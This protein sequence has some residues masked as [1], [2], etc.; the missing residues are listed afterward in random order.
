MRISTQ[1]AS[2]AALN[3]LM[4]AQRDA[5]DARGQIST[6]KAA[7]DLKGYGGA[8]ETIMTARAAKVRAESFV[9]ANERLA[10]RLQV[11]DLAYRELSGAAND[12]R[13][14]L[15]SSDG[16]GLMN[17]VRTAFDR[18]VGALSTKFGGS[19]VFG[20]VRTDVLPINAGSLADLQAAV[21]DALAVFDNAD[22]RQTAQI[23]EDTRLDVNR[24]ASEVAGGL[25]SAFER[26]ADF[27]AG[28]NGPFT[29]PLTEPQRLFIQ[30]E[31]QNVIAAFETVNEAMG[32]NGSN[33]A[34]LDATVRSHESRADYLE[35]MI[36]GLEDVDMAEAVSR[37]TQ[38][39]TAV[40]VSARTFAS[41]SQVSLLDY[42]R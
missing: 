5:F 18:T 35:Q 16:T 9:Q 29:T 36:S 26:I 19:Y 11:Q 24:T 14:A 4:K 20:G 27:D 7:P 17:E 41:L 28:P 12:L 34:R 1:A 37:M 25:I 31:I 33:Q 21:P 23:D 38:A 22:R 32:V 42:L 13:Q 40:D 8:L 3:D 39:Q 30:A 15:T 6:G 2:Q 10:N